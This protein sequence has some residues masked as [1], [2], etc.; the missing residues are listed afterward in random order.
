[1][2]HHKKGDR[3]NYNQTLR[4]SHIENECV[5][6]KCYHAEKG[7]T[8]SETLKSKGIKPQEF[9]VGIYK[10]KYFNGM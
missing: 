3:E 7:P 10:G 9:K 1:M 6:K 5:G 2:F 4:G 8:F